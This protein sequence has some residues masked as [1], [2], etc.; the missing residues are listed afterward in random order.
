MIR[1]KTKQKGE[2][3]GSSSASDFRIRR[4]KACLRNVV[5]TSH[6]VAVEWYSVWGGG[7]RFACYWLEIE[8]LHASNLKHW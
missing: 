5:V 2:V 4:R 8:L 6:K 1:K 3:G 7:R